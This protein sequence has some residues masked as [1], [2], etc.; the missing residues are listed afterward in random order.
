LES[1]LRSHRHTSLLT[2]LL[3]ITAVWLSACVSTRSVIDNL[4][5]TPH[6]AIQDS[7]RY[8]TLN[9]FQQDFLYLTETI[10]ESHPEPYAVWSR[11]EFD[12]EQQR[13][14]QTLATDTSR[15]AFEQSIDT[16]IS[17]LRDTHT[18]AQTAWMGGELQYPVSFFWIKDTLIVASVGAEQDT[19]LIGSRVLSFNSV[20][21]EEVFARFTKFITFENSYR[22][23]RVL[24]YYFVF[25]A[26]HRDAGI[27]S[28]PPGSSNANGQGVDTLELKLLARDGTTHTYRLLPVQQA[29]RFSHYDSH[30]VTGKINRPFIY[31]LLKNE[32]ACYM[33]FNTMV[34][35]RMARILSFPLNTL[36]Y[37]VA[38]FMGIGY[39]ENFLKD[40]VEEMQ[41]EGATTLIVDMRNNGGGGS[42]YGEQLLYFLDVPSSIGDY[43]MAI[44]FS[45]FYREFWPG[46]YKSYASQYA[47]K[48][49]GAKLPDSLIVTADFAPDDSAKGTYFQNV[50]D[51]KSSYYIEPDRHVFKGKVYFLVAEPTYSSAMILA[52]TVKDNKLFTIVGQPTGGRPSHYGET[53]ILKL[54]NSG[55]V[56]RIS[57]KKF[58]RPDISRDSEDSLYRDVEIWPTYE[59]YRYGRDPVFDWVLQDAKKG[60]NGM[61]E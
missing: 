39:F 41:E 45:P 46:P 53:L 58:F 37:P 52:S 56:C 15:V 49:G 51:T 59:D 21:T 30:P 10:R 3:L 1:N 19:S 6:F 57:C 24:Q 8:P 55:I 14:L 61:V 4:A 33:Q 38:W 5:K 31:K 26:Y 22:A 36:A 7:Q 48:R 60:R 11:Q 25:P 43:S 54:P 28:S 32:K 40:M 20:P 18:S 13:L 47:A 42:I 50:T 23:R 35:L 27:I 29:K 34:D 16:F 44:R 17:H 2:T 12:A 9:S